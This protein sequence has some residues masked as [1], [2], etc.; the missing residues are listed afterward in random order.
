MGLVMEGGCREGALK[1]A[2][3][4]VV[5]ERVVVPAK[6]EQ[7]NCIYLDCHSSKLCL[8]PIH[9]ASIC[10]HLLWCQRLIWCIR[11]EW[12]GDPA[13]GRGAVDYGSKTGQGLGV[14]A[15]WCI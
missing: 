6:W 14:T 2:G 8:K 12:W 4:R 3:R 5:A 13:T 7:R 9:P 15:R 11:G 1:E 10:P